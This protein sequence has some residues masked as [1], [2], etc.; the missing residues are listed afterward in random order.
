MRKPGS[1]HGRN[2]WYTD[3]YIEVHDLGDQIKAQSGNASSGQSFDLTIV[4]DIPIIQKWTRIRPVSRSRSRVFPPVAQAPISSR[5]RLFLP[6]SGPICHENGAP[7]YIQLPVTFTL[8]QEGIGWTANMTSQSKRYPESRRRYDPRRTFPHRRIPWRL[9]PDAGILRPVRAVDRC[10]RRSGVCADDQ[11][12]QRHVERGRKRY[13]FVRLSRPDVRLWR[14]RRCLRRLL[15]PALLQQRTG[16]KAH[17]RGP[18]KHPIGRR[19]GKQRNRSRLQDET[20][21]A[22]TLLDDGGLPAIIAEAKPKRE[23][24]ALPR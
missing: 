18:A 6:I 17:H 8:S 11:R 20:A 24:D 10:I 9:S 15:Q 12:H 13:R 4:V 3:Y 21:E 5:S 14:V 19:S 7:D 16:R 23:S 1:D 2:R 22:F